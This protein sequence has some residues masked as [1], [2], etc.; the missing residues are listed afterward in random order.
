M[1]ALVEINP[2][3]ADN[4]DERA[5]GYYIEVDA[6]DDLRFE[7]K[8]A[9][10][11]FIDAEIAKATV[12]ME[13]AKLIVDAA[14]KT[15]ATTNWQTWLENK[16][17]YEKWLEFINKL[18]EYKGDY[19]SD[20][21]NDSGS[22]TDPIVT[23]FEKELKYLDYLRDMGMIS[24]KEYYKQLYFL[25]EKYYSDNTDYLEQ[26]RDNE[27]KIRDGITDIEIR[28]I[29]RQIEALETLKEKREEEK[30]LQ[31]LQ[32]ELEEKKLELLN[33]QSQKN[34]RY[35]DAEK[36]E[37]VWTHNRED[38]ADAQKAVDEAQEVLD[39]HLYQSNEDKKIEQLEQ[40]KEILQ[41]D[42]DNPNNPVQ[43][44]GSEGVTTQA[45]GR[46]VTLDDFLKHLGSTQPVNTTDFLNAIYSTGLT[47][48]VDYIKE[49]TH[50]QNYETVN[51]NVTGNNI[52]VTVNG[53]NLNETQLAS[54]IE[55]GVNDALMDLANKLW[56]KTK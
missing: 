40:I 24:A 49:S 14:N 37:W 52:N 28:A 47:P 3:I 54:A 13:S 56:L 46:T 32:V 1:T 33:K 51:R 30:E 21:S 20:S 36:R 43:F 45:T 29:D 16:Q 5:D 25:N 55:S 17:E 23:A 4:I 8:K 11:E 35:Y 26:Y 48:N 9:R 2:E 44:V 15:K 41:G 31:E 50:N 53:S 18:N 27:V 34:V 38:V 19:Y 22:S 39:E 6:L 12:A 7:T 42:E 10:D